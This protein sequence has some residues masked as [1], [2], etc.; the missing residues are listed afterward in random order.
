[1]AEAVWRFT[2]WLKPSPWR[3]S[4]PCESSSAIIF[5][6]PGTMW[7]AQKVADRKPS[8]ATSSPSQFFFSFFPV[9]P[10]LFFFFFR[11]RPS[12]ASPGC[13]LLAQ[14][15]TCTQAFSRANLADGRPDA[16]QRL[17][18]MG[19]LARRVEKLVTGSR[20]S[21]S[22][23]KGLALCRGELGQLQAQWSSSAYALGQVLRRE[24]GVAQLSQNRTFGIQHSAHDMRTFPRSW[25]RSGMS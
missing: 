21:A 3:C 13:K 25:R 1:M 24:A 4:W 18:D 11:L 23:P 2:P 8:A 22:K 12:L 19:M 15:R 9:F 16:Q 10:P 6:S 14:C 7:C 20:A 17:K 5:E